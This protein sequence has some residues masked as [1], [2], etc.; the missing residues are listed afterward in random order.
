M[1][2]IQFYAWILPIGDDSYICQEDNESYCFLY[3]DTVV[4][5][6]VKEL[7]CFSLRRSGLEKRT[8]MI[9]AKEGNFALVSDDGRMLSDFSL[10]YRG[11]EHLA[12]NL[13]RRSPEITRFTRWL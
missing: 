12:S 5:S 4:F 13:L 3:G 9:A 11:A 8:Y 10:S 6:G 1:F 2:L 7:Y